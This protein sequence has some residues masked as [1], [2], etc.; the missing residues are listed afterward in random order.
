V[1]IDGLLKLFWDAGFEFYTGI[2]FDEALAYAD[3][4]VVIAP[5]ANAMRKMLAICDDYAL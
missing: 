2:Q 5:S 3:N 4:L 1:Y